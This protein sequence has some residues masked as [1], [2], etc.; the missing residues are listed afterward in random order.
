MDA[1][2]RATW[3]DCLTTDSKI[4][5]S[6]IDID[7]FKNLNDKYGHL[8]G[9][10]CLIKLADI[11]KNNIRSTDYIG[12]LGGEEFLTISGPMDTNDATSFFRKAAQGYL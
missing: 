1:Y 6:I 4:V 12:R 3:D 9:D 7:Y 10:D 8:A 11:L 5:V 2:L